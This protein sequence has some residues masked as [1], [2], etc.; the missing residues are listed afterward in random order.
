MR[1]FSSTSSK[2]AIQQ[3]VG[4]VNEQ[5]QVGLSVCVCVCVCVCAVVCVFVVWSAWGY[6]NS[7]GARF[8][9]RVLLSNRCT[10]IYCPRIRS[11]LTRCPA[12][13]ATA[14]VQP[15]GHE[16]VTGMLVAASPEKQMHTESKQQ[17]V[18]CRLQWGG[19]YKQFI[20][21]IKRPVP[22]CVCVC[23]CFKSRNGSSS[24]AVRSCL[25]VRDIILRQSFGEAPRV[26]THTHISKRCEVKWTNQDKTKVGRQDYVRRRCTTDM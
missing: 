20:S 13:K 12:G 15:P 5:T 11:W 7:V 4:C 26:H 8:K 17:C 6:G 23:V 1:F 16:S 22:L 3:D 18:L 24:G 25:S 9:V 14:P 2:L 10:P 19:W 21:S